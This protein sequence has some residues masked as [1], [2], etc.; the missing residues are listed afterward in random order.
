MAGGWG[1]GRG[2]VSILP[3]GHVAVPHAEGLRKKWGRNLSGLDVSFGV[4]M[5]P[6][7]GSPM[8]ELLGHRCPLG[9]CP[10]RENRK[11]GEACFGAR[12]GQDHPR[13]CLGPTMPKH[14]AAAGGTSIIVNLLREQSLT[15]R[16]AVGS[17]PDHGAGAGLQGTGAASTPPTRR[18]RL[19]C[20]RGARVLSRSLP[21]TE[22]TGL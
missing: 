18:H 11:R 4:L 5:D 16:G 2:C 20:N 17:T 13:A 3:T 15:A 12:V 22:V 9:D 21:S 1:L 7:V 8:W 10:G 19:S 14:E 6:G